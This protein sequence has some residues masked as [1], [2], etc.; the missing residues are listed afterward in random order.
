MRSPRKERLNRAY[1]VHPSGINR[2]NLEI[3]SSDL[4]RHLEAAAAREGQFV[5]RAAGTDHKH[6]R[7]QPLNNGA[8]QRDPLR[9]HRQSQRNVLY[10]CSHHTRAI[11]I[12]HSCSHR[13]PAVRRI[14]SGARVLAEAQKF[15]AQGADADEGARLQSELE[16][17]E[18]Q[19]KRLARLFVAG[20]LP[21][22]MLEGEAVTLR[23]RRDAI[24]RKLRALENQ[25]FAAIDIP[26]V[27]EKLPAVLARIGQWVTSAEGEDVALL[28]DAL[29]V[30]VAA[31]REHAQITGQVPVLSENDA[32]GDLLVTIARTW[33]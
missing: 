16:A 29:D 14:R 10:K 15:S 12:E 32:D 18:E 20:Q 21:E 6:V 28:F 31:S 24:E 11:S 22:D 8:E 2:H 19:Q 17:T 27:K 13:E 33:A 26:N 5:V 23:R 25:R 9:A 7:H 1:F 30:R 4:E 3:R